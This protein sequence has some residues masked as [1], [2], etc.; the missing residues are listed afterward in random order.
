MPTLESDFLDRIQN[1]VPDRVHEAALDVFDAITD[2]GYLFLRDYGFE[3]RTD[4]G[5]RARKVEGTYHVKSRTTLQI[6][7]TCTCD[8]AFQ[9][10]LC[11]HLWAV[12]LYMDE[13]DEG[14][15]GTVLPLFERIVVIANDDDM[16]DI[17]IG[18][19]DQSIDLRLGW[20]SGANFSPFGRFPTRRNSQQG[21]AHA[22]CQLLDNVTANRFTGGGRA[23]AANAPSTWPAEQQILYRLD[24][25]A[26]SA[27]GEGLFIEILSRRP[28]ANGAE[29]TKPKVAHISPEHVIHLPDPD[30]RAIIPL[31][32]NLQLTTSGGRYYGHAVPGPHTVVPPSAQQQVMERICRTGRCYTSLARDDELEQVSWLDGPPWKLAVQLV[33]QEEGQHLLN[34]VLERGEEMVSIETPLMLTPGGLVL[35]E[36]GMAAF[37]PCGAFEWVR[38]LRFPKQPPLVADDQVPALLER[39]AGMP[40][41]PQVHL[42]ETMNVEL[43]RLEP[44]PRLTVFQGPGG[45]RTKRGLMARLSFSYG[46][47]VI[48]GRETRAGLYDA[49]QRHFIHREIETEKALRGRARD[50]GFYDPPVNDR[51]RADLVIAASKLAGAVSALAHE[52]WYIEAEGK[53]HRGAGDLKMSVRGSG[54]DWFELQGEADFDG[55]TITLPE[56]LTAIKRGAKHI[57]LDDGSYGMLPDEWVKRYAPLIGMGE[58]QTD[59]TIRMKPTQI[60][61]IDALLAKMPEVDFDSKVEQAR[62]KLEDFA[63]IEPQPAPERFH[64]ELRPYQCEGLGWMQFL[65]RIGFGGCLADDMGLGKTVQVL[66]LLEKRRHQREQEGKAQVPS[67]VVAPRSL[68]HNWRAEAGRFAP[69]LRVLEHIG[70][71]RFGPINGDG[72]DDETDSDASDRSE[73]NKGNGNNPVPAARGK[74]DMLPDDDAAL[75][76]AA[77][78]VRHFQD[79]DLILTTYG[80]LRRD[81]VAMSQVGFDYVVLDEA[82]AIKNAETVS[83]RAVRLLQAGHRLALS[84]TPIENHLGELVSLFEFLNPGMFAGGTAGAGSSSRGRPRKN[85]SRGNGTGWLSVNGKTEVEQETR[86]MIA[87]AVRPFIL[88]RTKSQVAAE[89]PER[90]EQ[91]LHCDLESKQ[92]RMYNELREHYRQQLLKK[93]DEVGIKRAKFQVLEALLRLRQAACHPGLIDAEYADQPSAKLEMLTAQLDEVLA[94]NHKALVFSQFTSF[95]DI[96]RKDLDRRGVT[97]AYLDGKTTKREEV[98]AR[99]QDDPECK[100]FLISLKA[101]GL[102][103]NLTAAEYVF[104]LDPWWN[105]AVEAQA[106][107]RAHRIGQREHVFAYRL[108]ARDTV[109]EKVLQLQQTKKD[110]ADAIIRADDNLIRTLTVEDLNH[111]FG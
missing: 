7:A 23:S 64:G 89:L 67:L 75:T 104:L 108:I 25:Q 93:V 109:E 12:M 4:R 40:R 32:Q 76:A 34:G 60:G 47:Q 29:W 83:A 61:L 31:L 50:V 69:Q 57:E 87:H 11:C 37:D 63:G 66:A 33:P 1:S 36:E 111:L 41:L 3:G 16:D 49:T 82:Q 98:V 81:V 51:D 79:Y 8:E 28:R 52:G 10:R 94:E 54:I 101:G 84:G 107:D 97:Y 99:F 56:L 95:L 19:S 18:Q 68:I 100:L 21:K 59:G 55:H 5:P 27:D 85:G 35:F 13:C 43:T 26:S 65:E 86:E 44:K 110:L 39:L 92:R 22:W 91:T 106:I 38:P 88:R 53:V 20:E 78:A 6:N 90:T 46:E 58:Q 45:K 73:N 80:T 72:S 105:P 62:R 70:S 24:P 71:D 42:P 96:V 77:E 2:K 103:L 14:E 48:D 102:G 9:K 15:L 74:G 30:D 17:E